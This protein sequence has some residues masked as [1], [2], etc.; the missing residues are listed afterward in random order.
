MEFIDFK[1]KLTCIIPEIT[2]KNFMKTPTPTNSF[3]W[4]LKKFR[5]EIIHTKP[6]SEEPLYQ[7]LMKQSINFKYDKAIES[8]AK[9]M[10]F[11]QSDY[12]VECD[13]G[14]DY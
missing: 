7:D 9:L 6:K 3:I 1:T 10:N 13:C 14:K 4:N 12:I 2:G 8:V 11:Y 5:D